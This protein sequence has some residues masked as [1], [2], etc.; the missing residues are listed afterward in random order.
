MSAVWVWRGRRQNGTWR[1]GTRE[2]RDEEV[3]G[4]GWKEKQGGENRDEKV[5]STA[6]SCILRR[7]LGLRIYR[8]GRA[9][10]T[11]QYGPC[12]RVQGLDITVNSDSV[13]VCVAAVA[14]IFPTPLHL[15][16]DARKL[17]KRARV[18]HLTVERWQAGISREAWWKMESCGKEVTSEHFF[19]VY[20]SLSRLSFHLIFFLLS[21]FPFFSPIYLL[22]LFSRISPHLTAA[23]TN[24]K[25]Q[26]HQIHIPEFIFCFGRM[27]SRWLMR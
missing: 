9:D 13:C 2:V 27:H 25:P 19:S 16:N 22:P 6:C 11:L 18:F 12:A 26:I 4:R 17:K 23:L 5:S 14:A 15:I 20:L 1:S 10:M 21:F 8:P 7:C 3:R 24:I